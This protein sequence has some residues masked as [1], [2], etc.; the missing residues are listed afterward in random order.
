M[1]CFCNGLNVD[2]GSSDLYYKQISSTFYRGEDEGWKIF[3]RETEEALPVSING[4]GIK[5]TE[6]ADNQEKDFYF[7]A[8]EKYKGNRLASYGGNVTFKIMFEGSSG[9]STRK[10]L[11]LR[12]AVSS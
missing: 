3:V 10:K 7:S 11:D 9:S 2:C 4:E 6:F 8:P 5:F 12:I 1:K